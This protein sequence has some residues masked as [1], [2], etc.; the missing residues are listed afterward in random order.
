M[1]PAEGGMLAQLSVCFQSP[2]DFR[3]APRMDPSEWPGNPMP[4]F[5]LR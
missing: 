4:Y 5:D 1:N 2:E 3:D